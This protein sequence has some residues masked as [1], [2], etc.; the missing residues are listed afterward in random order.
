MV[1]RGIA[2]AAIA[3]MAVLLAGCSARTQV[4][5]AAADAGMLRSYAAPFEQVRQAAVA[6][7]TSASMP[8]S[9][10]RWLDRTRWSALGA[11]AGG[12]P[13]PRAARIVVEDHPTDCRVWTLVQSKPDVVD[14]AASEDLQSLVAKT[15]GAAPR[16]ERPISA[17]AGEREE[18]YRSAITRCS[19]LTT[20]ACRARGYQILR[21]EEGDAALRTITAEKKPSR[22]LF[23]ALYRHSDSVTRV[24]VEVRGG[25]PDENREDA[26]GVHEEL[27][28]ELPPER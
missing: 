17:G 14:E 7:L 23:A 19:E 13:A 5:N 16:A 21:Q 8:M 11:P 15:L 6:A 4:R 1:R 9:E 18:R 20:R 2:E 25:T 27:Q 26:F 24:V 10:E 28:K 22:R 3:A 12:L